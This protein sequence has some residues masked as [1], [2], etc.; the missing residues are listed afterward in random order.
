MS[1]LSQHKTQAN[2]RNMASIAH[3]IC[4]TFAKLFFDSATCAR[5]ASSSNGWL[6]E[7]VQAVAR[8][9]THPFYQILEMV[10]GQAHAVVRLGYRIT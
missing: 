2:L 6:L 4:D 3:Q 1:I 7:A 9:F 5:T 8:N 10:A